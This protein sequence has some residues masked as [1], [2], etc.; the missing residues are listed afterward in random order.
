MILLEIFW[1]AVLKY[2][3]DNN[4]PFCTLQ[5]V[6]SI[7]FIYLASLYAIGSTPSPRDFKEEK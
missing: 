3:N 4:L 2:L 1:G 6:K 5:I 7:S